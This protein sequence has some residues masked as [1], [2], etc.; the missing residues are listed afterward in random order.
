[1]K[2]MDEIDIL[3]KEIDYNSGEYS[4]E[5]ALRDNVLRKPLGMSLY[6][7]DLSAEIRDFHLGAF[8][9]NTLVGVL[10]LTKLNS[11]EIKMRQVAIDNR[12]QSKKIG[13]RLVIF[14]ENYAA[15]N[16]FPSIV[17]NARK[18]AVEFYERLGYTK[19][20]DEFLEIN[21]PHFKMFKKLE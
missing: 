9:D 14:A 12:Y 5:L 6:D 20:S 4:Q 21:I 8:I 7:E 11:G 17:L 18:T 16:G 1:M 13:S 19:I 15:D 3:I 2:T 10:I